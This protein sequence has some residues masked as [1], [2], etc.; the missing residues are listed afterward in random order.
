MKKGEYIESGSENAPD[1]SA[2]ISG[3]EEQRIVNESRIEDGYEDEYR[4]MTGR[5]DSVIDEDEIMGLEKWRAINSSYI[6]L[7][8]NNLLAASTNAKL[9]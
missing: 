7:K 4:I 2:Y 5:S 9:L 8:E 6:N 3:D 1:D